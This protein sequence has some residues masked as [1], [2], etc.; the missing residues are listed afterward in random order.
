MTDQG[1]KKRILFQSADVGRVLVSVDKLNETGCDVILKRKQPRII[2]ADGKI[3]RLKRRGG[4]FIFTMWVKMPGDCEN[5][6]DPGSLLAPIFA[7]PA[8]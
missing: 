7:R 3:V 8:T 4:V 5:T 1:E 2:T 6:G